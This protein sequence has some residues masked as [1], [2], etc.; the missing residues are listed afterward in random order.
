M[1]IT[2]QL[3]EAEGLACR[4]CPF[5]WCKFSASGWFEATSQPWLHAWLGRD[6]ASKPRPPPPQI[7]SRTIMMNSNVISHQEHVRIIQ[8]VS[9]CSFRGKKCKTTTKSSNVEI[10]SISIPGT[11]PMNRF[12]K[13]VSFLPWHKSTP[14]A[15]KRMQA[16]S[17]T[18]D[19]LKIIQR[20]RSVYV[21]V[22][23]SPRD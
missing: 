7:S 2:D 11:P 12:F 20:N 18:L 13:K 17:G 21:S 6:V 22:I 5:P 19:N 10:V 8:C 16:N 14:Y 3:L 4:L 23:T 15:W 9:F 1:V